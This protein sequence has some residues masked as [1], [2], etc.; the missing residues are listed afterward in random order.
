MSGASAIE[1]KR[2]RADS[3][4]VA[5]YGFVPNI[6]R[7]QMNV[8][9]VVDAE[10]CLIEAVFGAGKGFAVPV[11]HVMA[12]VRGSNYCRALF[13]P[14]DVHD[15]LTMFVVKLARY[16][17]WISKDDVE[18]L[19]VTG[20]KD[21]EIL[22][23][24][25]ATALGQLLCTLDAGLLPA[26]DA[27]LHPAT[28]IE[29]PEIPAPAEP[30][31]T[32]GPYLNAETTVAPGADF[33]PYGVLRE[34]FGFVPNLFKIQA[35]SRELLE[36]EVRALE[37]VL[38]PED[39]LSRVQKELIQLTLAA[40]NFSSY[41]VALYSQ[42][43]EVLGVSRKDSD[44]IAEDYLCADISEADKTLLGEIRKLACPPAQFAAFDKQALCGQ[45]FTEAQVVEA[46]AMA[47]LANLLSPLQF[48]LDA[49][50]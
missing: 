47:G 31:S 20:I 19:R 40:A 14:G 48:G 4:L 12:Q 38:F 50:A 25:A 22:H 11:L 23:A 42:V 37:L 32:A 15:P 39:H 24:I 36:A 33:R 3:R 18:A 13:Q 7:A 26:L 43:L 45:G 6:F 27:G 34:Q 1:G 9:R 2:A 35:D 46:I 10:A 16:G 44:Q 17:P 29:L 28:S 41:L 8:E 21:G 49:D 5:A 30:H